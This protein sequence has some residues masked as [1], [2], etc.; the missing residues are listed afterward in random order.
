MGR[1]KKLLV[2]VGSTRFDALIRAVC[3]PLC[4][5]TLTDA[6]YNDVTLQVGAGDFPL[7]QYQHICQREGGIESEH[8]MFL[9]DLDSGTCPTVRILGTKCVVTVFRFKPSLEEDISG[10][11]LV[12]SHAGAGSCI[13]VLSQH[14]PLITVSNDSLMDQHQTEL[15]DQLSAMGVCI[16]CTPATLP[17]ALQRVGSTTLKTYTPGD[18]LKFAEY[19]NSKFFVNM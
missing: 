1:T 17:S 19:I 13:E 9:A 4:L 10:A 12:I 11:S 8:S 16:S 6:G 18:T 3:E 2:T 15:A 7:E 5:T 14:R